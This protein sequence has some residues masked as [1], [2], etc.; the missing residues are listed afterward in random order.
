MIGMIVTELPSNAF[1]EP[2]V[3]LLVAKVT[4]ASEIKNV[5][6]GTEQVPQAAY[7][8]HVFCQQQNCGDYAGRLR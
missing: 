1:L 6:G 4:G 3:V 2:R 8:S 5:L 7:V